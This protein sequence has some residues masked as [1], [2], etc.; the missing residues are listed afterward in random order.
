RIALEA[1]AA[2][3]PGGPT[4]AVEAL[5]DGGRQII[6]FV[7]SG[8]GRVVEVFGDLAT[9]RNVAVVVGGMGSSVENF[10]SKTASRA[11]N[12]FRRVSGLGA[13]VAV[14]AWNGYDAPDELGA[15]PL[16]WTEV[17][18]RAAADEGI[19]ELNSL[20]DQLGLPDA[21]HL[22]LLGHSYGSLVV[23]GV[24]A[25]RADVDDVVVMGSPG[26]GGS[27]PRR[28][29]GGVRMWTMAAASDPIDD[30]GWF[31]GDPNDPGT[32]WIPVDVAGDS[33]HGSYLTDGSR[34]LDQAALVVM[35][36]GDE[37]D[38]ISH[39]LFDRLVDH[40]DDGDD[41]ID[42]WRLFMR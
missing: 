9:A 6:Q 39:G 1:Q 30:L 19:G 33:G 3:S 11:S 29:N 40:F 5:L 31:G 23:A 24:A 37:V 35:G 22:T 32:G 41:L 28:L 20:L 7:P 12:L 13:E 38:V 26:V 10:D 15:G 4:R 16:A 18:S 25:S 36:R 14:V 2:L 27:D 17:V 8:E 21:V 42:L 34:S